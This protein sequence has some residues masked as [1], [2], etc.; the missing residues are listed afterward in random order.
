MVVL[1]TDEPE[2][3]DYGKREKQMM[4]TSAIANVSLTQEEIKG[5]NEHQ[6]SD[7]DKQHFEEQIRQREHYFQMELKRLIEAEKVRLLTE[8]AS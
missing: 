2:T 7:E 6:Q 5:I 4:C 1:H 8:H 3:D